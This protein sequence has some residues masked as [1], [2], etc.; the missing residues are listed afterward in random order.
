MVALRPKTSSPEFCALS[1]AEMS[2]RP[3]QISEHVE[4]IPREHVTYL[5]QLNAIV[6]VQHIPRSLDDAG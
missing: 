2:L 6:V 3:T 1:T 5:Y 4:V